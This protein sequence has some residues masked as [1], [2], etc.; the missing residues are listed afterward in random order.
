MVCK[1][2]RKVW[3]FK[4]QGKRDILLINLSKVLVGAKPYYLH[5]FWCI[6]Q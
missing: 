6:G 1:G 3:Y 4:T 5:Q 2:K